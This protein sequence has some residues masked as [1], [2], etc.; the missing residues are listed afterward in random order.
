MS[1]NMCT[2]LYLLKSNYVAYNYKGILV[3]SF[4]HLQNLVRTIYRDLDPELEHF[5][6]DERL[7]CIVSL[8][9]LLYSLLHL[10]FYS[11]YSIANQT[12]VEKLIREVQVRQSSIT[13]DSI[14]GM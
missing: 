3:H 13:E 7:V 12:V 6:L 9:I 1:N 14:R 4:S 5:S 2:Q 11:F 10:W 8:H